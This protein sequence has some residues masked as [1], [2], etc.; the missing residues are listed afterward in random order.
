MKSSSAFIASIVSVS[1]LLVFFA[2]EL[3]FFMPAMKAIIPLK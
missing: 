3:G 1:T 2:L